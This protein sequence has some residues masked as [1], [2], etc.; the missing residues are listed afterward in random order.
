[1]SPGGKTVARGGFCQRQ[2]ISFRALKVSR[3]FTIP[4]LVVCR[5]H[6][7]PQG[8]LL[9]IAPNKL[10]RSLSRLARDKAGQQHQIAAKM[11]M[12]AMTTSKFNQSKTTNWA[13]VAF[14]RRGTSFRHKNQNNRQVN[15]RDFGPVARVYLETGVGFFV[16]A[17]SIAALL[18][19]FISVVEPSTSRM[20]GRG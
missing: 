9:E 16:N 3:K 2:G 12:I 18:I 5:I 8:K 13:G 14:F 1:M 15:I 10:R 4:L 11:A 20:I 7:P 6:C 19:G 17:C